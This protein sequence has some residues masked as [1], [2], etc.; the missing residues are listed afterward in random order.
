M[1]DGP[2]YPTICAVLS[3]DLPWAQEAL[4]SRGTPHCQ[5]HCNLALFHL[6][7]LLLL[8]MLPWS[9]PP[10]L[11]QGLFMLQLRSVHPCHALPRSRPLPRPP[12]HIREPSL[13]TLTTLS[14]QAQRIYSRT[15]RAVQ[16]VAATVATQVS[17]L[18]LRRLPTEKEEEEEEQ[19]EAQEE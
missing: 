12:T 18:W 14:T 6:L 7:L 15:H 1:Q 2:I 5:P 8:L 17:T 3:F 11:L 10:L 13:M 16:T 9:L 4:A 19:E